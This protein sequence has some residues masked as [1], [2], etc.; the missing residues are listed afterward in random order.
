MTPAAWGHPNHGPSWGERYL[1]ID[2]STGGVRVVYGLTIS[3]RHGVQLRSMADRNRDGDVDQ[4]EVEAFAESYTSRL[5]KNVG[6][7]V[8]DRELDESWVTPFSAGLAGVGARGP[9]ALET[10]TVLEVPPGVHVVSIEDRAEFEGIYRTTAKV[11]AT[12]GVSII[13][14][15]KGTSPS[16]RDLRLVFLDLP[17]D[18]PPP[19]RIMTTEIAFPGRSWLAPRGRLGW[20]L[21]MG[22]GL[23]A[24]VVAA[25]VLGRRRLTARGRGTER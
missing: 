9:V 13:R 20:I 21:A 5:S 15:G 17:D 8:D 14:C 6:I 18:G 12:E 3:A 1:K 10:S 25:I 2:A 11:V 4:A 16:A 23:L 24:L 22:S 7:R 19:P